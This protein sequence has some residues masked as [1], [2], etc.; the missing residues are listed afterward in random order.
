MEESNTKLDCG[1][2][3]NNGAS[4]TAGGSG[5]SGS[6][7]KKR[8]LTVLAYSGV[9]AFATFG[10]SISCLRSYKKA[11]NRALEEV[12]SKSGEK[13]VEALM[14]M[15]RQLKF[16]RRVAK[17]ALAGGT[18]LALVG[19]GI[20]GFGVWNYLSVSGHVSEAK[21]DRCLVDVA[22]WRFD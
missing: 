6:P 20:I 10:F 19:T 11:Y 5:S 2:S 3:R 15:E 18:V 14:E 13:D 21:A 17:K 7:G 1:N 4:D 22:A 12:D 16:A 9:G 8:L